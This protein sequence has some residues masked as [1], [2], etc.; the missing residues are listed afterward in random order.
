[1]YHRPTELDSVITSEDG[2]LN[3]EEVNPLLAYCYEELYGENYGFR[4]VI[5]FDNEC[6]E[7]I[8]CNDEDEEP[9]IFED[10]FTPEFGENIESLSRYKRGLFTA[11]LP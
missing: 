10:V 4:T 8:D 11:T 1:M 9:L 2:I 6:I 5:E 3:D 7:E